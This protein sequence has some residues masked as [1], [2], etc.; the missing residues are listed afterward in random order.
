MKAIYTL[1]SCAVILLGCVFVVDS[2]SSWG[3]FAVIAASAGWAVV[4]TGLLHLLVAL[5]RHRGEAVRWLAIASGGVLIALV[6]SGWVFASFARQW[7]EISSVVFVAA[8]VALAMF[9]GHSNTV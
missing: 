5:D 4:L 6:V 9:R 8:A 2:L 3:N 1:V 7:P